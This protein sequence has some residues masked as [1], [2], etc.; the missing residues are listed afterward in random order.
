MKR[1]LVNAQIILRFIKSTVCTVHKQLRRIH[2]IRASS[3]HW[4]NNSYRLRDGFNLQ[5]PPNNRDSLERC[6]SFFRVCRPD[7]FGS[8]VK[9]CRSATEHVGGLLLYAVRYMSIWLKTEKDAREGTYRSLGFKK[10]RIISVLSF[11][12]IHTSTLLPDPRSLK[13]P[14]E[15]AADTIA[16]ASSFCSDR[17]SVRL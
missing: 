17:G 16:T 8:D 15:I 10:P 6:C 14:A 11:V 1:R 12:M 4:W 13:I 3:R 5:L 9:V 7:I 2:R